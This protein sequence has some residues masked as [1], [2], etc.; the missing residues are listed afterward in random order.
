[1][2]APHAAGSNQKS[3]A[4]AAA[5][6]DGT[7]ISGCCSALKGLGEWAGRDIALGKLSSPTRRVELQ[8]THR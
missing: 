6:R 7:A 3:T 1:V 2:V 5:A 4:P 8:T